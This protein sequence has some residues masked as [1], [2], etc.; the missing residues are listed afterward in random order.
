MAIFPTA[1]LV[2]VLVCLKQIL[3][4]SAPTQQ[5]IANCNNQAYDEVRKVQVCNA[6]QISYY[7][8]SDKLSCLA[9]RPECASCSGPDS[10]SSCKNGYFL[11]DTRCNNCTSG[12]ATCSNELSCSNCASGYY[13]SSGKCSSCSVER[14]DKCSSY[15]T[16]DSCASG[17]WVSTSQYSLSEARSSS[18]SSSGSSTPKTYSCVTPVAYIFDIVMIIVSILIGLLFVRCLIRKYQNSSPIEPE[19]QPSTELMGHPDGRPSIDYHYNP[20]IVQPQPN[21][22]YPPAGPSYMAPQPV[23]VQHG[24]HH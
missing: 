12:C 15:K 10:C 4:Q 11:L 6:C 22:G 17:Y 1:Y 23:Y 3:T 21:Y 18:R 7:A 2:I 5:T 9:C 8:S 13:L 20:Q 19:G 16:C 14:C 24:P